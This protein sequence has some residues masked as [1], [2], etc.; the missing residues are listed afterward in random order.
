MSYQ[1]FFNN[2]SPLRF[3]PVGSDL[4]DLQTS[5]VTQVGFAVL[6]TLGVSALLAVPLKKGHEYFLENSENY[7]L[8]FDK[9]LSRLV[10]CLYKKKVSDPPCFEEIKSAMICLDK[11]RRSPRSTDENP[12][13]CKGV[14]LFPVGDIN[15]VWRDPNIPNTICKSVRDSRQGK[16]VEERFDQVGKAKHICAIHGFDRL[17]VP[18]AKIQFVLG[19]PVIFEEYIGIN[20][21]LSAQEEYYLKNKDLDKAIV[22]LARFILI[23][24]FYDVALRNIPVVKLAGKSCI[25]LYDLESM[26]R[27]RLSIKCSKKEASSGIFGSIYHEG[28]IKC[29]HHQHQ[30]E[31]VVHIAK[32]YGFDVEESKKCLEERNFELQKDKE[33]EKYHQDKGILLGSQSLKEIEFSPELLLKTIEFDEDDSLTEPARSEKM[34]Q[35]IKFVKNLLNTKLKEKKKRATLKGQRKIKLNRKANPDLVRID[36]SGS[37]NSSKPGWLYKIFRAMEKEGH[38]FRCKFTVGGCFSEIQC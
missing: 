19:K 35:E 15:L 21:D 27:T 26:E 10:G 11:I 38:I 14:E 3:S 22:Q 32:R 23:T 34:L 5:L 17:I 30:M 24:G 31:K 20:Q 28:L 12:Q 25:V 9:Y 2:D 29:L 7:A 8:G 37:K 13:P 4:E 1:I 18:D 16:V 33:L 36:L 6:K